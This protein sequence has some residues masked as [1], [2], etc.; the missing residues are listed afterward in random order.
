MRWADDWFS[1]E[2]GNWRQIMTVGTAARRIR[3]SVATIGVSHTL[4][5][6]AL[7]AANRALM[8]K[9]LKGMAVERVN[10]AF[11]A[12]PEPYR[13]MFLDEKMLREFCRDQGNDMPETFIDEA[14]SKDD[15]C[16]GILAGDT[17]AA[18]GWYSRRPTRIDP[19]DLEL[20]PGDRYVY[21]YKGF[22]HLK[23]RGRRLHAIGMTLALQHYL[24][25]GFK[26]LVSYVES[27]N[28]SS[29]NSVFRMG[30]ETFGAIYVL[31]IF[32]TYLTHA[33]A[34]CQARGVRIEPVVPGSLSRAGLFAGGPPQ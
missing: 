17:L 20:H 25:R 12:C 33:S 34:G 9:I 4:H 29:L 22:T 10:A 1:V 16:Y 21:M 2:S 31:K 18:Y 3:S 8:I 27:N 32:G 30:Y 19:P 13:P 11:L 7:R 28:F 5:D 23:H 24:A 15:E 26:G 14:L 6:L